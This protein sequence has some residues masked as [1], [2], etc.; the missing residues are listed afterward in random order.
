LN[1]TRRFGVPIFPDRRRLAAVFALCLLGMA[2][3]VGASVAPPAWTTDAYVAVYKGATFHFT[4][5]VWRDGARAVGVDD[6]SLAALLRALGATMTWHAG[7]RDVFITTSEPKVIAFTV[8]DSQYGVGRVESTASFAPFLL[9]NEAYLPLNELL[10]ALSLGQVEEQHGRVHMLVPQITALDV[11]RNGGA[12]TIA[13]FA[14]TRLQP[15]IAAQSAG[16]ITYVFDGVGSTLAGATSVG[17]GISNVRVRVVGRPPAERTLVTVSLS[18]AAPS[19]S[20][21]A[22]VTGVDV[23]ASNEAFAIVVGVRGDADYEWHRLRAPD[24]RFWIDIEGA[25]LDAPP[26]QDTW[27]NGDVTGVRVTQLTPSSVRVAL[28]LA[29]T[30]AITVVPSSSGVRVIV[31]NEIVASAPMS[32][33]GSVGATVVARV[34]P[35][36]Q[37][38]AVATISQ[39]PTPAAI[40][41][42]EQQGIV[43]PP[44]WK[45]GPHQPYAPSNPRLI[46][47]DPGHGGEDPGTVYRGVME[48]TLTLDMAK[49]L[50]DILV[51]R[52]WEVRMTRTTDHDVDATPAST[53]EAT[54]MGYNDPAASDLQARDDIANAAGAR[55]FISIH[56]NAC[57]GTPDPTASG[58]MSFYS[59]PEDAALAQDVETAITS[60]LGTKDDGIVKS[61]LYVTLHARMP[62]VLVETAFLTNPSDFANL[63]SPQWRQRLAEAIADGIETYARQHPAPAPQP[64]DNQ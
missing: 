13:A 43:S 36:P 20:S 9:G 27:T 21:G 12:T 32:G 37:A 8:N 34:E 30:Q 22:Q 63:V 25:H 4:H 5:I 47:I 53:R 58:T 14:V 48:K 55:L 56:V 39:T 26:R 17:G 23:I 29:A 61:H 51:A 6:P 41:N 35:T 3:P 54:A 42:E 7:Q 18:G 60:A 15:R 19:P 44:G 31:G 59:K 1:S 28:S 62:A 10:A 24:D 45:F 38:L 16:Q 11:Q 64:S 52:G 50:R 33:S 46:V 57:C 2:R 49:R 40:E